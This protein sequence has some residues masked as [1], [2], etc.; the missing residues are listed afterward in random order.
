MKTLL[1]VPNYHCGGM[2]AIQGPLMNI[3]PLFAA[4]AAVKDGHQVKFL[5]LTI[6]NKKITDCIAEIED[7]SPDIIGV[8]ARTHLVNEAVRIIKIIKAM[9]PNVLTLMGGIHATF[10]FNEIMEQN[11]EVDFIIRHEAEESLALLLNAIETGSDLS[12]IP[13]LV[14]RNGGIVVNCTAPP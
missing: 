11:D 4:S 10:M 1:I 13:N 2:E 7:F 6:D 3:G 9:Y 8:T 12:S 14:W 5:D